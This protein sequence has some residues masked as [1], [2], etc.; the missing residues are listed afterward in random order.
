MAVAVL[1]ANSSNGFAV[2]VTLSDPESNPEELPM[3]ESQSPDQKP[4]VLVEL[5]RNLPGTLQGLAAVLGSL[6]VLLALWFK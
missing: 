1:D 5:I 3:S 4:N 2:R 6:A